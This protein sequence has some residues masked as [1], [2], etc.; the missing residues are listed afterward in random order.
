MFNNILNSDIGKPPKSY[1]GGFI[2][3]VSEYACYE[4]YSS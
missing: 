4:A 1:L 3:G 2:M